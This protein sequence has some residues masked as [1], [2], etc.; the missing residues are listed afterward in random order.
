MKLV[1][2]IP[3]KDYGA[4]AYALHDYVQRTIRY[5]RDVDGIETLQSPLKTL[6]YAQ[7]D[8]DDHA[9][10]LA[11]LLL[12]IGHTVKFCAIGYN[13]NGSLEHVYLEAFIPLPQP[14]HWLT[15]E[16][17]EPW[18]AGRCHAPPITK[19]EMPV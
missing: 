9:T 4:E 11:A 14:G 5:T 8:C 7:G 1:A 18:K 6:D 12:S 15:L 13:G 17:T 16:T 2:R 10:L 19:L 3:N